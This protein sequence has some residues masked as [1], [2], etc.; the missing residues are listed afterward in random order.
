MRRPVG[1]VALG[2]VA[3]L[4]L[5]AA[6][7]SPPA[8]STSDPGI[9]VPEAWAALH[10]RAGEAQ[11]RPIETDWLAQF[12]DPELDALI[13]EAL[14]RNRDLR[15]AAARLRRAE[16][17]AR[18]AGADRLPQVGARLDGRR[19]RSNFFGLD[20]PGAEDG[21][22]PVLT[23]TYGVSL[24]LS[25]EADLWGR[26]RAAERAALADQRAA[27]ATYRGARLSV[28][29]QTAKAWFALVAAAEQRA[30]A[31]RTLDSYRE[32][33]TGVERRYRRG[34]VDALDVRLTRT[35]VANA[36]ALLATR[37]RQLAAAR[38]QLEIL[39]GRYP[40]AEV[41]SRPSLPGVP[42]PVPA[43]LPAELVGRRPDVLVARL[44]L[45]AADAR[46]EQ[47][48]KA[49]YPSLSLTGSGGGSAPAF[50][51]LLDGDFSVWS[52]AAS[53]T[54]PIFQGGRLRANV[55][56][57]AAGSEE[58]LASYAGTLLAAYGEVEGTLEAERRLAERARALS[59]AEEEAAAAER[60]ARR[61]YREGLVDVLSLLESQRRA[62]TARSDVI[63]IRR[64]RLQ[65]RVDL[66]LALGG[67]FDPPGE[68]EALAHDR[69]REIPES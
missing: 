15:A 53:L 6:C 56:A 54:Q 62:L 41:E 3:A 68:L 13:D 12:E 27:Y 58:A 51:D 44:E 57:R 28:A 29:A 11:G 21:V 39:I 34:L 9:D 20:V 67:G 50:R 43:G 14:D 47:A 38:R 7:V 36:E 10:P 61:Q 42:D 8:P 25:W 64:E 35:N 48:R 52:L 32:S 22:L 5:A 37:E 33:L 55:D 26:L 23:T 40:A 16:A 2:A 66:H 19:Q 69:E 63:A 1:T 65:N 46:V 18:A 60:L 45:T 31:E 59:T 4:L 24:E 17:A 49:L 30:L